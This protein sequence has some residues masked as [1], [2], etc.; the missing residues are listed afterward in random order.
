MLTKRVLRSF[1]QSEGLV[2][3]VFELHQQVERYSLTSDFFRSRHLLYGV[4]LRGT[5]A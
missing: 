1:I 2:D 3:T 5:R 4:W